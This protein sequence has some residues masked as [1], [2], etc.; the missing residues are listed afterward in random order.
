MLEPSLKGSGQHVLGVRDVDELSKEV[1]S[2]GSNIWVLIHIFQYF[3]SILIFALTELQIDIFMDMLNRPEE[4]GHFG[5][6]RGRGV[7]P[8]RRT[9]ISVG[10]RSP[11]KWT[12]IAVQI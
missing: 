1:L 2:R 11:P 3:L 8:P 6:R 4:K 12:V 5:R 7:T 10:I 9:R